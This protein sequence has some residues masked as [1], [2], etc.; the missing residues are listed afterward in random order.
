[1]W[2]QIEQF[3]IV[4]GH[5][6][7]CC[8]YCCYCCPDRVAL[9]KTIANIYS[10]FNNK[11][12]YLNVSADSE[13]LIVPMTHTHTRCGHGLAGHVKRANANAFNRIVA[14]QRNESPA[15]VFFSV[16]LWRA[17]QASVKL[18]NLL[19]LKKWRQLAQTASASNTLL[20]FCFPSLIFWLL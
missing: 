13:D 5:R 20:I 1:M 14:Q 19:K 15:K 11:Y 2:A 4:R 7:R 6:R 17:K 18:M 9:H 8:C 12:Q 3:I 16:A 10:Y